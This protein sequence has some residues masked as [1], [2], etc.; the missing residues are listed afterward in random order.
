MAGRIL[1]IKHEA[2][3]RKPMLKVDPPARITSQQIT[4]SYCPG[5]IPPPYGSRTK[6][7]SCFAVC[8]I[9]PGMYYV[10]GNRE[11]G[12]R[13]EDAKA[14]WNGIRTTRKPIVGKDDKI[15]AAPYAVICHTTRYKKE[16]LTGI[17]RIL[18]FGKFGE[19]ANFT[20]EEATN[21]LLNELE[22]GKS[23]FH[24]NDI[25][26]EYEGVQV[27]GVLRMYPRTTPGKRLMRTTP[28]LVSPVRDLDLD[29]E[30][31]TKEAKARYNIK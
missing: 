21:D 26:A 11:F 20:L 8:L 1:A 3:T 18:G 30:R 24:P 31:I 25:F 13:G 7:T 5:Y 16:V 22:G 19:F 15:L 2:R 23:E 12:L 29:L 10:L 4:R 6:L 14:F 27:V 17:T 9:E 28:V